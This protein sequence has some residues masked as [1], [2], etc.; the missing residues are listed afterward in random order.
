LSERDVRADL[1][2]MFP[3]LRDSGWIQTSDYEMKYNC[4]AY[5]ADDREQWWEPEDRGGW[6]W[7]PGLPKNDFSLD[8]Y[9]RCFD[10]LG[11][12]RC[13]EGSLEPDVEKIAVF[14]D[15]ADEFSHVARQ[16]TD[17]WWSS[18]LG[19]YEDISHP[20]NETLLCGRPIAYGQNLIFMARPRLR[21]GPGRSG[22]ILPR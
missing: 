8:N 11:F 10:Y 4:V 6:Y 22:L 20:T 1:E 16:L 2:A 14:V 17:G 3:R 12:R 7:P 9:L 15:D 18:K 19:V 21:S 5:I 13:D